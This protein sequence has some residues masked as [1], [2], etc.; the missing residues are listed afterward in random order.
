MAASATQ[1]RISFTPTTPAAYG[2]LHY[3]VNG[4][5]QQN[6]RMTNNGGTWTQTVNQLSAGSVVTYW[7]TEEKSGPQYPERITRQRADR[8]G[9]GR[10]GDPRPEQ[11]PR[12]AAGRPLAATTGGTSPLQ[13]AYGHTPT[14]RRKSKMRSRQE[15]PGRRRRR[16]WR[17]I[18]AVVSVSVLSM[19]S[20]GLGPGSASAAVTTPGTIVGQQSGRCVDVTSAGTANGT[21]TQIYDCNGTGAQ[22][23]QPRSDGSFV[24]PNSNRCLDVSAGSTANGARVQIYD[25]NGTGAQKW[26]VASNG[27]ITNTQSGKCL[28][29][30]GSGNSSYLQIWDCAGTANQHWTVNGTGTGGS[31]W[32]Q[33]KAGWNLGNSF[34]ATCGETCWGNPATTRAMIDQVA[35][36]F[37]FLRIPVTWYP[38]LTSGSPNYTIDP[39]FLARLKQVV[40]WAIA[41]GMFVDINVHHDGGGDNWL[42]PSSAKLP[43]VEPEFNAIWKQAASYFSSYDQHLLFES[44][45]EPQDANGGNRYGGGTS[46]NWPAINQLNQDFV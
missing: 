5:S 33:I 21:M 40:D 8:C 25:C 19:V 43:Q 6:F 24:N 3:L 1:A 41:D 14:P 17:T 16:P 46:D 34:D 9:A 27:N 22:Q 11:P 35:T 32:S 39:V 4:A 10:A 36:K 38:H 45:N 13:P 31:I 26:Q 12:S 44:M 23:W 29:A 20:A 30:N 7:F 42:I 15:R 28:D 18:L 37:N 2:D